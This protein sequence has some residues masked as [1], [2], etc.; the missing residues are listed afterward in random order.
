MRPSGATCL[1]AGCCFIELAKCGVI[2]H[3]EFR[4]EYFNVNVLRRIEDDGRT[5]AKC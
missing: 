3:S 5:D 1:P 4:G 2:L